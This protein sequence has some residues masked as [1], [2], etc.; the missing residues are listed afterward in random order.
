MLNEATK[1]MLKGAIGITDEDLNK[2]SPGM[3]NLLSKLENLQK[4]RLVAEVTESK[5][6]FRQLKPGQKYVFSGG[7]LI[8]EETTAPF[9]LSAVVPLSPILKMVND[10][11]ASGADPDGIWLKNAECLDTG[12]D[13]GGLGK[14]KFKINVVKVS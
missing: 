10:R 2:L 8:Q 11:I 5:Y 9:C 1:N 4:Y 3:E 12:I 7:S 6:C 13:N 14:V